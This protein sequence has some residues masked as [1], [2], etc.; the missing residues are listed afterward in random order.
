MFVTLAFVLSFNLPLLVHIN[1]HQSIKPAQSV[2][3]E[4]R[5]AT[6]TTDLS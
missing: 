4:F 5:L 1:Q 6:R 2:E 3:L